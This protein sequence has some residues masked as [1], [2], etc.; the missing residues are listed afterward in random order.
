MPPT[1]ELN[2]RVPVRTAATILRYYATQGRTFRTRSEFMRQ[3]LLDWEHVLVQAGHV[4]RVESESEALEM[5]AALG[6][7]STTGGRGLQS[8]INSMANEPRRTSPDA[9]GDILDDVGKEFE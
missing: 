7:P 4:E 1:T 9:A 6:L 8:I 5:F 3:I 2:T